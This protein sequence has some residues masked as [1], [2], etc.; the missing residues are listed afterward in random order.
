MLHLT[1]L[2]H[3]DLDRSRVV[4]G[5]R[6]KR[7]FTESEAVATLAVY[8]LDREDPHRREPGTRRVGSTLQNRSRHVPTDAKRLVRLRSGGRCEVPLC[9]ITHGLELAHVVAHQDGG[10]REATDLFEGC[11][12]HHVA[13]DAGWLHVE[14]VDG[15]PEFHLDGGG[16]GFLRGGLGVE[17]DPGRKWPLPP[18][19]RP[20]PLTSIDGSPSSRPPPS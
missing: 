17:R 12:G 9:D 6:A 8:F 4:L 2:E 16:Y 1:D 14:M 5:D 7:N 11:H 10:G 18:H 19:L 13:Y 3:D 15:K 20:N